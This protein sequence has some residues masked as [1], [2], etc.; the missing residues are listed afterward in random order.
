MDVMCT[1]GK[2]VYNLQKKKKKKKKAA[3][4]LPQQR[5]VGFKMRQRAGRAVRRAQVCMG[6]AKY[7][8]K[9]H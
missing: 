4:T 1:Q 6:N 8:R 7:R 5:R 3:F 9:S 2:E